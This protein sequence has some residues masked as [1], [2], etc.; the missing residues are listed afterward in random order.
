[1]KSGANGSCWKIG[2]GFFPPVNSIQK[3]RKTICFMLNIEMFV[4]N[5]TIGFHAIFWASI[6]CS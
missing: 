5:N 1:M 2:D 3:L 6:P 4:C